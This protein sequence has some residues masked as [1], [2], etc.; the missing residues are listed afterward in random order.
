MK[1]LQADRAR[2]GEGL[3]QGVRKTLWGEG[4]NWLLVPLKQE[5]PNDPPTPCPGT[6]I[7]DL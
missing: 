2:W 1:Q 3:G 6:Q 7:S 4:N 5:G